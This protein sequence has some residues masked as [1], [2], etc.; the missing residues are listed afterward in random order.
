DPLVYQGGSSSFLAPTEDIPLADPAWGLDFEGEVA[1]ILGDVPQGLTAAQAARS[2][3]LVML[4][5]DV[6]LRNLIPAELAKGFG[7][8]QSKPASSF[9]PLAVTPDELGTSF[10]EGRLHRRLRCTLNGTLVGDPEAGPEM[11][12]SFHDL[13][14]HVSRTR[15]FAAGTIL[16]SG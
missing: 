11:H 10:R 1:V 6:T 15:S 13:V 16:G 7:F 12:F 8:F 5:N 9:S 14:A 4:C 3:K 2:V